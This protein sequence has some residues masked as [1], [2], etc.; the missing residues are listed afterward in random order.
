[1]SYV[2]NRKQV[3]HNI[4]LSTTYYIIHF[5]LILYDLLKLTDY[6]KLNTQYTREFLVLT[7]PN[8]FI[9]IMY[10]LLRIWF[11]LLSDLLSIH[12]NK[13]K[14]FFLDPLDFLSL[15]KIRVRLTPY[16]V[17][18]NYWLVSYGRHWRACWEQ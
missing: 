15:D 3:L 10:E 5:R 2:L 8:I 1:M 18:W 11:V 4:I 13:R 14:I 16:T 6:N 9:I 7:Q 12:V 17:I